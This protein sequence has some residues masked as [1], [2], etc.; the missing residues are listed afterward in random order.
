MGKDN[1]KINKDPFSLFLDEVKVHNSTI[2]L[3]DFKDKLIALDKVRLSLFNLQKEGFI[4]EEGTTEIYSISEDKEKELLYEIP[5]FIVY[6]DDVRF[7][8]FLEINKDIYTLDQDRW[9][10]ISSNLIKEPTIAAVTL[11][12]IKK[13]LNS[14]CL[15][16]FSIKKYFREN[17]NEISFEQESFNILP[18][19]I[20]EFYNDQ[21]IDWDFPENLTISIRKIKSLSLRQLLEEN[22]YLAFKQFKKIR[23]RIPEKIKAQSLINKKSFKDF[24]NFLNTLIIK[25]KIDSTILETIDEFMKLYKKK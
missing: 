10:K 1:F 22:L 5:D 17:Q 19:K 11:C 12:W 13:D 6:K 2:S 23:Y 8:V 14:C 7:M 9:N 21:F 16:S 18:E 24:L 25:E 3:K 20:K 4:V 15:D